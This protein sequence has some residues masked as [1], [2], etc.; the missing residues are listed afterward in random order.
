MKNNIVALILLCVGLA[1]GQTAK[2]TPPFTA[3]QVFDAWIADTEKQVVS[4]AAAMPEDKFLFAPTAGE[5]H[6]VRTFAGQIKHLAANNFQVGAMIL[7]EKPPHGE[8]GE[9]APDSVRTKKEVLDYLK[10]SFAYLHKAAAAI[11]EKTILETLPG[12]KGV[13]QRTRFG[14]AIDAVAHCFDHYGQM[15]EYLR[16]NGIVPP[17]SR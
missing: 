5:F 15:V 13:W 4:A 1:A 16:M 17:A 8:H 11:D 7:G 10:G 12:S 2:P 14:L 3:T 9:E 6:G